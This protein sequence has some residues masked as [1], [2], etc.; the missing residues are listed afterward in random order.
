[1]LPLG[2]LSSSM[3]HGCHYDLHTQ[4]EPRNTHTLCLR[5]NVTTFFFLSSDTRCLLQHLHSISVSH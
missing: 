5:T 1:M 3:S 2:A 4:R